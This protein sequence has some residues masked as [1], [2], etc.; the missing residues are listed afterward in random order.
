MNECDL[1]RLIMLTMGIIIV[2][3]GVF[4]WILDERCTQQDR[5][6]SR[7]GKD[8]WRGKLDADGVGSDDG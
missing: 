7:L 8:L 5:Y 4:L 6:I 2:V 1:L 3:G